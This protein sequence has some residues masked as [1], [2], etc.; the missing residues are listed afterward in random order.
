MITDVLSDNDARAPIFGYNSNLR[1]DNYKVFVKTGTTQLNVDGWIV[2]C[3]KDT[4][5]GVWSG[6]NDNTPMYGGVGESASGPQWRKIIEKS[7]EI[8]N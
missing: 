8:R 2:G 3:T 7:V 1:F 6:N 4:C 5:V